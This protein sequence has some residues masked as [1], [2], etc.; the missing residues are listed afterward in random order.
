MYSKARTLE[1]IVIA[2]KSDSP[3]SRLPRRSLTLQPRLNLHHCLLLSQQ[4][5]QAGW[6]SPTLQ[7]WVLSAHGPNKIN[8]LSLAPLFEQKTLQVD[9]T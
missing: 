2:V 5:M 4:E 7:N 1:R 9:R 3:R 8:G 6:S